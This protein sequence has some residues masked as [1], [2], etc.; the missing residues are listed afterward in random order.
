M[1]NKLKAFFIVLLKELL[2]LFSA[3]FIVD[4]VLTLAEKHPKF[5]AITLLIVILILFSVGV[6]LAIEDL[7]R[8]Y[9]QKLKELEKNE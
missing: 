6:I 1:K 7:E 5:T 9:K 4:I 8:K 2:P 3:I